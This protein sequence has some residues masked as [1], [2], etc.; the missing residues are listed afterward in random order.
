[1]EVS[2]NIKHFL[3]ALLLLPAVSAQ[4]MAP[5]TV[6]D[7]LNQVGQ[8]TVTL[9]NQ[10]T[11]ACQPVNFPDIG[12][13]AQTGGNLF[14]ARGTPVII[15][16]IASNISWW[17][18]TTGTGYLLITQC[19]ITDPAIMSSLVAGAGYALGDQAANTLKNSIKNPHFGALTQ[20]ALC[21]ALASASFGVNNG[22]LQ[23][24]LFAAAQAMGIQTMMQIT[25][26]LLSSTK[27]DTPQSKANS[28]TA[29]GDICTGIKSGCL[30][31]LQV[32]LISCAPE[33]YTMFGG[34]AFVRILLYEQA[35]RLALAGCDGAKQ[36]FLY[37]NQ[38]STQKNSC[39]KNDLCVTIM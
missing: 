36:L 26:K 4:A 19:S 33:L 5:G 8:F 3:I 9:P 32:V 17:A 7:P 27:T 34:M 35:Y 37:S 2:M 11:P 21:S 25:G 13:I 39:K 10:A 14:K 20:A 22:A 38:E 24:T 1:M 18:L 28:E 31:S 6:I 15:S 16:F 12:D 23:D 30:D 29:L